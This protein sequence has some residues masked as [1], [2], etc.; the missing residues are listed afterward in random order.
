MKMFNIPPKG[1]FPLN[2][3][4]RWRNSDRKLASLTAFN[5]FS[6]FYQGELVCHA[7]ISQAKRT[8]LSAF[9][10]RSIRFS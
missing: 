3:L 9:V 2:L 6:W 7:L 5:S 1:G 8:L 10:S 4:P